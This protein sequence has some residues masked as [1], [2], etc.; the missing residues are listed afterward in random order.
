MFSPFTVQVVFNCNKNKKTV[1]HLR[2]TVF[3]LLKIRKRGNEKM[4]NI[5]EKILMADEEIKQL[6]NKRKSSACFSIHTIGLAFYTFQN[7]LHL[8]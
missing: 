4:K 1:N 6:Q 7:T 2:F 8:C 5:E 3:S